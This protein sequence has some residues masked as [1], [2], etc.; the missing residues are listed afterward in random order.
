[1]GKTTELAGPQMMPRPAPELEQLG[2]FVGRWRCEGKMFANPMGPEQPLAATFEVKE[3]LDGFW[4][5]ARY[6]EEPSKQR[7]MVMRAVEFW[8]YDAHAKQFVNHRVDSMGGAPKFVADGWK[9]DDFEWLGD[10]PLMGNLVPFKG[11]FRRRGTNEFLM[12]PTMGTPDG[13][14][15]PVA[16][17]VCRKQ[18]GRQ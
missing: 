4:L 14:W 15:V 7:P 6:E 12:I 1:M 5:H 2:F 18:G 9:G 13:R 17:L 10:F 16:E 8:G 11:T 3:D